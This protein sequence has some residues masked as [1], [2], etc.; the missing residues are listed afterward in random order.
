MILDTFDMLY[1]RIIH[2]KSTTNATTIAYETEETV[3]SPKPTV[4]IIAAE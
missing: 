2:P 3:I 1:E 4:K